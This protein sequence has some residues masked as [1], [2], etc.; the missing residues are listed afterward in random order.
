[1]QTLFPLID[2]PWSIPAAASVRKSRRRHKRRRWKCVQGAWDLA[3]SS[4]LFTYC[5]PQWSTTRTHHNRFLI[6]PLMSLCFLAG[7]LASGEREIPQQSCTEIAAKDSLQWP[8]VHLIKKK[9]KAANNVVHQPTISRGWV[10]KATLQECH[11]K[12]QRQ[13]LFRRIALVYL[14]RQLY[15]MKS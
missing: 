15:P 5:P 14:W 8:H 13:K 3:G 9:E 11:Y 1:M 12:L 7:L 4:D 6:I 10:R 2:E